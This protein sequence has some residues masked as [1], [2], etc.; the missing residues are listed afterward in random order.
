MAISEILPVTEIIVREGREPIQGENA[1]EFRLIY[2]GE[3]PRNG[4]V[5]EKFAIRRQFHPQLRELWKQ[6]P[7]LS[8][9]CDRIGS[10]DGNT[11][12]TFEIGMQKMPQWG[13]GD[14]SFL[15]LAR[16]DL[17]LRCSLDILFLRREE[18]GP[19]FYEGRYRRSPENFV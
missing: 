3:L 11:E 8:D 7:L 10:I 15:P 5:P 13:I 14:F 19:D 16:K 9:L 17:F 4:G 1:V 2:R 6:H 18:A 12:N